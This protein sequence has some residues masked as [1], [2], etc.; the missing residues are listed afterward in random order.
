MRMQRYVPI[1]YLSE[2]ALIL[3]YSSL[4]PT[5]F[6]LSLEETVKTHLN[7]VEPKVWN[8]LESVFEN[9]SK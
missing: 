4:P 7:L 8:E 9:L 2:I 3:S 1:N 5:D 6:I